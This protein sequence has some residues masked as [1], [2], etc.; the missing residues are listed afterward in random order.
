MEQTKGHVHNSNAET[1][2]FFCQELGLYNI[3]Y[4]YGQNIVSFHFK[5]LTV[6]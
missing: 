2:V 1:Y 3:C 5:E 4:T 6:K